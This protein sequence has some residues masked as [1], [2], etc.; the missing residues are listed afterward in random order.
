LI[1]K[2]EEMWQTWI[3]VTICSVLWPNST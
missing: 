3:H 2:K 1:K